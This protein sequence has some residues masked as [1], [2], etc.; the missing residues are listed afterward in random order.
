[1]LL[2]RLSYADI[3]SSGFR[4][5]QLDPSPA[6]VIVLAGASDIRTTLNILW[7]LLDW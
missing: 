6:K 2:N 5:S 1:M 7:C 4:S 3:G